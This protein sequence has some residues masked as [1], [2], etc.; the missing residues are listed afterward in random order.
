MGHYTA[1]ATVT[2]ARKKKLFEVDAHAFV[3][4]GRGVLLFNNSPSIKRNDWTVVTKR[5]R[6]KKQQEQEVVLENEEP[7]RSFFLGAPLCCV[8]LSCVPF[9]THVPRPIVW[10]LH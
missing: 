8:Y 6:R 5:T 3:N 7:P 1:K 9:A 10:G 2:G 4:N